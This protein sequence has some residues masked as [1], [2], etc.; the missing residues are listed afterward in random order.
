MFLN[1]ELIL[2]F[3]SAVS[4]SSDIRKAYMSSLYLE[5]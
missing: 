2:I 5:G 3:R 1:P 4:L